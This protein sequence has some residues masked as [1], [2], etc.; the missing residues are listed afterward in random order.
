LHQNLELSL[1]GLIEMFDVK[2]V[3]PWI[4]SGWNGCIIST[5]GQRRI[6]GYMDR[7]RH[8]GTSIV[9]AALKTM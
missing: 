3:G 6:K 5:E 4:C 9:K 1:V 7:L 8:D 2:R